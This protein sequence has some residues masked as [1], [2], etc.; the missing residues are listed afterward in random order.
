MKCKVQVGLALAGGYLLGRTKR[1]KLALIVGGM[2][3]GRKLSANPGELLGRSADML[4]SNE[5]VEALVEQ[6]RTGLLDA[7][8]A[9]AIAA[10]TGKMEAV[11][12]RLAERAASLGPSGDDE[13]TE[14]D[15]VSDEDTGEDS[16]RDSDEEEHAERPRRPAAKSRTTAKRS[17]RASTGSSAR[18]KRPARATSSSGRGDGSRG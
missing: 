17:S 1:M 6:A 16:D 11:S 13:E 12:D 2:A 18:R 3:A 4:R 14:T 7:G 8:K 15:D 10:A 9:A 5:Q